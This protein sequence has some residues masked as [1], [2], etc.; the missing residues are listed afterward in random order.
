MNN[1]LFV[2]Q[3]RDRVKCIS[4]SDGVPISTQWEAQGYH[5]PTQIAQFGLSHYSKNLTDPEPRR[6][7]KKINFLVDLFLFFQYNFLNHFSRL[8]KT[9]MKIN[10][11][12]PFQMAV[13]SQKYQHHQSN[14]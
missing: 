6:K 13:I 7:V 5:Y 12:G 9:L 11:L 3:V 10:H 14:I 1:L 8:L 2:F 4:A